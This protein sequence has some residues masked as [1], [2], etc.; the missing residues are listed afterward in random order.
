M[1][2]TFIHGWNIATN[3]FQGVLVYHRKFIYVGVFQYGHT[4]AIQSTQ[5]Y[6][7]ICINETG[8]TICYLQRNLLSLRNNRFKFKNSWQLPINLKESIE[9]TSTQQRINRNI[10]TCNQL[11][12]ETLE[13]RPEKSPQTLICKYFRSCWAPARCPQESHCCTRSES[14]PEKLRVSSSSNNQQ[15]TTRNECLEWSVCLHVTDKS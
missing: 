14:N 2:R 7:G 4:Y 9:Y 15:V 8:R 5:I 11:D 12:L 1:T 10:K 13:F 6:D 3:V